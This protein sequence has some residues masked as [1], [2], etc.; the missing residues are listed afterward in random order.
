MC[1]SS[2]LSCIGHRIAVKTFAEN[3]NAP[4]SLSTAA[5]LALVSK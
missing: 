1:M 4:K 5:E 3:A 2:V